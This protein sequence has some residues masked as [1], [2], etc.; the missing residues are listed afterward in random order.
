[1]VVLISL[2]ILIFPGCSSSNQNQINELEERLQEEQAEKS[3]LLSQLSTTREGWEQTKALLSEVNEELQK[4]GDYKTALEQLEVAEEKNKALESEI[5]SLQG[6]IMDLRQPS[7][8]FKNRYVAGSVD[9]WETVEIL[10]RFFPRASRKTGSYHKE[11]F[12]LATLE[13]LEDFLANDHTDTRNIGSAYDVV[14]FMLKERWINAGLPPWSFCLARV[15]EDNDSIW[16]NVFFT[17]ENG[18]Y[19]FYG[20]DW[21]SDEIV[22]FTPGNYGEWDIRFIMVGDRIM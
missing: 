5:T 12:K 9:F 1:M 13:T 16:Q 2:L 15:S 3:E 11:P 14:P 6:E 20:I 7:L 17:I 19:A 8:D 10:K 4:M 18:E 22:K 21:T